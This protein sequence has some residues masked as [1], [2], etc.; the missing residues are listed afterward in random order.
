MCLSNQNKHNAKSS[1]IG[2]Q[3]FEM[4]D[5]KPA[6]WNNW[7]D[8]VYP[9][10]EWVTSEKP[11]E[12]DGDHIDYLAGF[13]IIRTLKEAIKMRESAL[14]GKFEFAN[15][16]IFKVQY[17]KKLTEGY[18]ENIRIIVADKRKILKMVTK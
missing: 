5:G 15:S 17:K 11:E 13:H 2:Y 10:N 4:K 7:G 1:G 14:F 12:Y 3:W 6:S 8:T 18:E 16:K 9:L